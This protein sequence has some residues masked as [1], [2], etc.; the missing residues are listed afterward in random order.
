MFQNIVVPADLTERNRDAVAM[1]A[2]LV[3]SEGGKVHLLHVIE[4][5]P[6]FS[7]DE[8]KDFYE[9]LEKAATEHLDKLAE[10]LREQG[11]AFGAEVA[12][13]PRAKTILEESER[14]EADLIVVSSH[15]A[16]ARGGRAQEG[17]GTLSYQIGIFADLPVLLVK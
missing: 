4:T 2:R 13:G 1:A 7:L 8:E 11:I 14:L 17:W 5:I 6:G 3:S 12:Y 9:K 10:P 15:R 16:S